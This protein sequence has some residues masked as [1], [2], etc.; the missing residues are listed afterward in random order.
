VAA[1]GT[2]VAKARSE[3]GDL[4]A[5]YKQQIDRLKAEYQARL[6]K[7]KQTLADVVA[8]AKQDTI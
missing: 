1:L 6:E 8:K 3:M 7:E 2:E 4:D 5:T